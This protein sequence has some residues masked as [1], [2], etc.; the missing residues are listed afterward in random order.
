PNLIS[1]DL[2][3]RTGVHPIVAMVM[4]VCCPV[5]GPR[6]DWPPTVDI[7]DPASS[8]VPTYPPAHP[9]TQVAGSRSRPFAITNQ[10]SR[11]HPSR[12][13]Q[14]PL[15]QHARDLPSPPST[16]GPTI[17]ARDVWSG[18]VGRTRGVGRAALGRG[19]ALGPFGRAVDDQLRRYGRVARTPWPG[20]RRGHLIEGVRQAIDDR[21]VVHAPS[22]E[23]RPGLV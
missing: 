6:V 23:V 13:H 14:N 18:P 9:R 15:V 7:T 1:E 5:T 19:R 16:P 3:L 8:E 22:L 10:S 4:T 11:S 17:P 20:P 2:P 12:P 21:L